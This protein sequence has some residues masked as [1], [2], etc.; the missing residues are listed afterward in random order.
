MPPYPLV[1]LATLK[2][3]TEKTARTAGRSPAGSQVH[4]LVPLS[5][6]QYVS[7]LGMMVAILKLPLERCNKRTGITEKAH[8]WEITDRTV[9][10]WISKAV[11]L[12]AA[13]RV[14][15]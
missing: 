7:Q 1:Q 4:Q 8:I 15:G 6:P 3:R 5:E 14:T 12:A 10:T 13:D 2:Q 9:P 11:A